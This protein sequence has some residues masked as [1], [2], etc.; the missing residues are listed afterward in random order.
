MKHWSPRREP[1]AGSARGT[2]RD[3]WLRDGASRSR[4]GLARER[5][6]ERSPRRRPEIDLLR[7]SVHRVP[8]RRVLTSRGWAT[9]LVLAACIGGLSSLALPARQTPAPL[10]PALVLQ[11]PAP[12]EVAAAEVFV[13]GAPAEPLAPAAAPLAAVSAPPSSLADALSSDHATAPRELLGHIPASRRSL[14]LA[15]TTDVA[16]ASTPGATSIS[17]MPDDDERPHLVETVAA[18]AGYRG[19][20]RVE[21]TL[22]AD[23]T[24]RIFRVLDRVRVERGNVVVLDVKTGRVLAYAS[25]NPKVLPPERAYPAAS[26][27]KVVTAAAALEHD[28]RRAFVP[29]RFTGSPYRLTAARV[30]PARGGTEV[31]LEKSLAASYNQC[32]AQLAV[33]ALGERPLVEAFER[34]GWTGSAG[35]GQESGAI[36]RGEGDYGLGK[37]GSGLAPTRITALHAAQLAATLDQGLLVEPYW[38][39]RIVDGD[40]VSL[41]LPEHSAPSRA[42]DIATASELRRMLVRTTTSGTARRAFRTRRG[43]RLGEIQVAGKTGNLSGKNPSARYEWFAGVAPAERPRVAIA[44]VQAHGNR[45]WATSSQVAAEVL[46]ELFC[47]GSRCSR[48]RVARFVDDVR[49]VA[50]EG[51]GRARV[52]SR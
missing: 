45:W 18:P 44:V 30:H 2:S 42:M 48:E 46:A 21:Y 25:A 6:R 31:S 33:H 16:V 24:R 32:F 1:R 12:A 52:A 50:S 22:D 29:C 34:F 41:A 37:L 13:P 10:P 47:E 20:L 3:G 19:P 35:P 40:G 4:L 14:E 17:A 51:S 36:E 49:P 9:L 8:R 38:I 5:R 7:R 43:A 28:R 15:S 26:L 23:L 27:A 11:E 39:D